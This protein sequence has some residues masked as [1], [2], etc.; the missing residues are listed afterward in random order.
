MTEAFKAAAKGSWRTTA[1]GVLGSLMILMSNAVAVIDNDPA[2]VINLQIVLA[3]VGTLAM[4]L[5]LMAARDNGVSSEQAG[6]K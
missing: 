3:E 2:T 6:A 4:G 1:A 5:G